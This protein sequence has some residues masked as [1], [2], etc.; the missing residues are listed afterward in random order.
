MGLVPEINF[1]LFIYLFYSYNLNSK[2]HTD[3]L[4]LNHSRNRVCILKS[5]NL[6]VGAIKN[7]GNV[8]S[9]I[10]VFKCVKK[11]PIIIAVEVNICCI[12]GL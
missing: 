9:E 2:M 10:P 1:D 11:K 8:L 12:V 3:I 6:S 5:S 7:S 4:L